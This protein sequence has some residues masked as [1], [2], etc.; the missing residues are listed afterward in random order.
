M[1]QLRGL[2]G[3]LVF[4]GMVGLPAAAVRNAHG[5]EEEFRFTLAASARSASVDSPAAVSTASPVFYFAL[6][7]PAAE[8]RPMTGRE[9]FRYYLKSTYGPEAGAYYAA[10]AGLK[11]MKDGVPEWGQGAEG[12]GKRL[13]SSVGRRAVK[14]SIQMG[15]GALLGEDPR[16]L[17]SDQSGVWRRALYAAGSTLV[18]QKDGGGRR[19][20][21][22][23]FIGAFGASYISRQWH[24]ESYRTTGEYLS[25][26]AISIGM[27]AAKNILKEFWPD[28]RRKMRR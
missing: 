11:Q 26:G 13:A 15:L 21:Y 17:R 1:M 20:A 28:I 23:R 16:Y 22:S 8:W 12:Y 14:Y 24:P 27:D 5:A 3:V 6:R 25:S 19:P 10:S 18:A 7:K 9:K 2:W 4:F